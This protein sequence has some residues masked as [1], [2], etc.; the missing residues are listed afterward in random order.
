MTAFLLG[1]AL[2][3]TYGC[4]TVNKSPKTLTMYDIRVIMIMSI[5]TG[6]LFAVIDHVIVP[7][8]LTIERQP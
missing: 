5:I 6:I 1:Y 8:S 4:F 7:F 2:M 3:F